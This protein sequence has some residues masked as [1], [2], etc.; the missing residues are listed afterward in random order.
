[1]FKVTQLQV[2]V[3]ELE[4]MKSGS[5]VLLG[6]RNFQLQ[7]KSCYISKLASNLESV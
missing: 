5:K 1:M 6:M 7:I 4:S 2:L 3:S